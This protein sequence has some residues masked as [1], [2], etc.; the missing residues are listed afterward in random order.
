VLLIT[1]TRWWGLD[2]P[3]KVF[4]MFFWMIWRAFVNLWYIVIP[5]AAIIVLDIQ[6]RLREQRK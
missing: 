4:R 5:I 6:A 1:A 3:I 2:H